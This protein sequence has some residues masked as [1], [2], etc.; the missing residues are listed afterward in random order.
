MR[1][2]L[3]TPNP[4]QLNCS[5]GRESRA[6]TSQIRPRHGPPPRPIVVALV[7]PHGQL[8]TDAPAAQNGCELFVACPAHIPFAGGQHGAQMV[9]APSVGAIGQVVRRI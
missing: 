7:A 2:G 4:V 9:V 3:A 6:W 5:Y 1:T 8:V